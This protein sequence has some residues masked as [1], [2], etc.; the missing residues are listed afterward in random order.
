M[1]DFIDMTGISD[2]DASET[3]DLSQGEMLRN[4]LL[5][6]APFDHNP[7]ATEL[8]YVGPDG[9]TIMMLAIEAID[10][11]HHDAIRRLME[12]SGSWNLGAKDGAGLNLPMY[13]VRKWRESAQA[14]IVRNRLFSIWCEILQL[15]RVEPGFLWHTDNNGSNI[16]H[17]IY[18]TVPL[19][20]NMFD[21]FINPCLEIDARLESEARNDGSIP[22]MGL[23]DEQQLMHA[24]LGGRNG[25]RKWQLACLP[26]L[27]EVLL[28][29]I[30]MMK[31]QR[32]A[33]GNPC[34]AAG[35]TAFQLFINVA[36]RCARQHYEHSPQARRPS[37]GHCYQNPCIYY[38]L[39]DRN[40]RLQI[41]IFENIIL[42]LTDGEIYGEDVLHHRDVNGSHAIL[43]VAH[44]QDPVLLK[45]LSTLAK[46]RKHQLAVAL[47][48][49]GM[50]PGASCWKAPWLVLVS[51]FGSVNTDPEW[52]L[53]C[54]QSVLM[55]VPFS[56]WDGVCNQLQET[57]TM[58]LARILGDATR[59]TEYLNRVQRLVPGMKAAEERLKQVQSKAAWFAKLLMY[60]GT[61]FYVNVN[62]CTDGLSGSKSALELVIQ[63]FDT[64][65]DPALQRRFG[66]V[67]KGTLLRGGDWSLLQ[68]HQDLFPKGIPP[69]STP[70]TNWYQEETCVVCMDEPATVGVFP[71]KQI[72]YCSHCAQHRLFSD[73]GR[74][75]MSDSAERRLSPLVC[76]ITRMPVYCYV[77]VRKSAQGKQ[78]VAPFRFIPPVFEDWY[79]K[80][81]SS[82]TLPSK[83]SRK[84]RRTESNVRHGNED[85]PIVTD[86]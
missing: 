32:V 34:N 47:D 1:G 24:E 29:R 81:S 73:I 40:K 62:M 37:A 67:L 65:R 86:P 28:R 39:V 42:H 9:K 4:Q 70:P 78:I 52:L 49:P 30:S 22:M 38:C 25:S 15:I 63:A 82:A 72:I 56:K 12:T 14:T 16:L 27:Y 51:L 85:G 64:E 75:N 57:P 55:R 7:S 26:N 60:V 13:L 80:D 83:A 33:V 21:L 5:G 11:A 43:D 48:V 19:K 74:N 53:W 41:Q 2:D 77:E 31:A 8:E 20:D 68:Y 44:S 23:F 66:E 17:W 50:T 71:S 84:R 10:V 3:T 45:T 58:E 79:F 69:E 61:H 36:L 6:G 76:M 18:S 35:N 59:H 46:Y 54:L